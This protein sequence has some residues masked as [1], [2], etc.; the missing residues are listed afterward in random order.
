[1]AKSIEERFW[2]KVDVRGPDECWEWTASKLG[3]GYGGIWDGSKMARAHRVAWTLE[4]G[5][6]PNNYHVCHHCDNPRCVN[7]EHLFLGAHQDNIQD[8]ANKGR[9]ACGEAHGNSRLT[10]EKVRRARRLYEEG[11]VTFEALGRQ[12]GVSYRAVRRA[13]RGI[14]WKHVQ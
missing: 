2:E 10:E 9:L 3:G 7:V 14:T 4:I 12:L 11:G 8:A 1:M 13:V 6:I 5:S